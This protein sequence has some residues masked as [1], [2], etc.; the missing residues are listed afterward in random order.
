MSFFMTPGD[1]AALFRSLRSEVP[2]QLVWPTFRSAK[3][4]DVE[5]PVKPL[6]PRSALRE[7]EV[8]L[9]QPGAEAR[10][11]TRFSDKQ[12]LFAIDKIASEVIE[13]GR[14]PIAGDQGG[15]T[16]K[17]GRVWYVMDDG[18]GREKSSSF[19]T[20]ADRI[21][22]IMRRHLREKDGM[23]RLGNE[24]AELHRSG[25]ASFSLS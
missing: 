3:P 8:L 25:G 16:I 20:W 10:V 23:F 19:R 5:F 7:L 9:V 12:E 24:A 2:L 4:T 1:E 15:L 11:I 13:F 14:S 21:F 17:P 22:R 18:Y 6:T